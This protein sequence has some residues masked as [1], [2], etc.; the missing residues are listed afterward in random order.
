LHLFHNFL[1]NLKNKISLLLKNYFDELS[2]VLPC[3]VWS[4]ITSQTIILFHVHRLSEKQKI[5]FFFNPRNIHFQFPSLI[6]RWS[7]FNFK[8]MIILLFLYNF[9]LTAWYIWKNNQQH[10]KRSIYGRVVS[11]D[12][13]VWVVN[14]LANCAIDLTRKK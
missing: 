2:G 10:C 14:S 7:S 5:Q 9:D 6:Y 1:T 3:S 8:L 11:T 4:T 13:G 12:S